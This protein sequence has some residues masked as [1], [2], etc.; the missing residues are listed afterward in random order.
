M[1]DEE[2]LIDIIFARGA[3]LGN[4]EYFA[5]REHCDAVL[6]RNR[7]TITPTPPVENYW[8]T[9]ADDDQSRCTITPTPGGD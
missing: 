9:G 6:R 4:E 2:R 7:C 1:T 5:I 8:T 3:P